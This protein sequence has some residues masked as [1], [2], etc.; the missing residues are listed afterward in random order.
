MLSSLLKSEFY[1]LYIFVFL[2]QS[3]K[4]NL[5]FFPTWVA[6][7]IVAPPSLSIYISNS[8]SISLHT[9]FIALSL[10][11]TLLISFSHI[12]HCDNRPQ[13]ILLT[14]N[15]NSL[16]MQHFQ[17][18]CHKTHEIEASRGE[19]RN[20]MK[21]NETKSIFG[22]AHKFRI[23]CS[24]WMPTILYRIASHRIAQDRIGWMYACVSI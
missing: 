20:K 23:M 16:S 4:V 5:R 17:F 3:N 9:Y 19:T 10:S 8:S 24:L 2:M 7:Y 6:F 22:Q 14:S 15:I 21:R 11:L 12:S 13:S 1:M 18:I